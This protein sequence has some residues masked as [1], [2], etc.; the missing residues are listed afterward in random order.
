MITALTFF[1]FSSKFADNRD[2]REPSISLSTGGPSAL[3][4]V[5]IADGND[6]LIELGEFRDEVA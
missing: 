3:P 1:S 6:L 2:T 5:D 4:L